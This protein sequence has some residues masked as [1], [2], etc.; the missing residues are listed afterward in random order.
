MVQRH[1][2]DPDG[3][4]ERA[5]ASYATGNKDGALADLATALRGY[6]KLGDRTAADRVAEMTS[7]IRA[8]KPPVP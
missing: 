8:G 6:R 1:P 4:R 7:A 2:D 5:L 3:Y